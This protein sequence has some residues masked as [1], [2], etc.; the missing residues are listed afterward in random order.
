MRHDEKAMAERGEANAQRNPG[1]EGNVQPAARRH[2]VAPPVDIFENRDEILLLAD[3]PGVPKD[4]LRV[5]WDADQ[6][7]IEGR[8]PRLEGRPMMAALGD[9]EYARTFKVPAGIEVNRISASLD[10]GVLRV[11]LPKAEAVRPREIKIQ[12]G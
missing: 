1:N 12:G 3:L 8:R 11:R 9:L 5:T 2:M 7:S 4:A 6:L 10:Q